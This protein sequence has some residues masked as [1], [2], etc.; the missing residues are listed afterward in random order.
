MFCFTQ[1]LPDDNYKKYFPQ[2][3]CQGR[4]REKQIKGYVISQDIQKQR[5]KAW[6][7]KVYFPYCSPYIS[8][9]ASKENLSKYQDISSLVITF[10]ILITWM[11]EQV[12]LM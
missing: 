10:F 6:Y 1:P 2:L 11:F 3:R 8:Y 12:V 9:G 7:K 5:N 4:L